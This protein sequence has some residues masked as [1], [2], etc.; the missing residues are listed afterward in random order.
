MTLKRFFRRARWDDERARELESYV[1][2]ETDENIA[3]G[4][5]PRA[6]R[7]AAIRKLGNRTRVREDIYRMNT[8]GFLDS[9]W[10]DVRYGARLLRLNPGFAIV[11]ILS[12][13]LGIGA[14]TA[15]FELLNALRIRS[16]PVAHP[17]Q[18]AEV[19]VVG[20]VS[21]KSGWFSGNHP[22]LTYPLWERIRDRQD[23]F[24]DAFAFSSNDFELSEHGESRTAHG[25]WVSGGF[26]TT[27]AVSPAAGRLLADADDG[28]G[29]QAPPVA[30]GYGFWQREFGGSPAAV[31]RTLTLDGHAHEIAGVMPRSFS[32]IEVGRGLDV[33]V[34]LCAEALSRGP[35]SALSRQDAWFLGVMGR[36]K[37]G[38]SLARATAHLDALSPSLF[39]ETLPNYPADEAKKYLAF[40]L[41]AVPGGT[42][43][44]ELRDAYESPL[45][46]LLGTAGVVLLI[47]CA[48]L[49]NLMLARATA[50]SREI[51]VRLAL[52]ASR[53]RIVRQ[54]VA[55]SVLLAALGAAAAA[56][57]ARVLSRALVASL[58]TAN[59]PIVVDVAFDWR[60]FAF[61]AA[62]AGT[63]CLLFG[64]APAL[65]ATATGPVAALK[66]G[67]R[68]TIG[69]DGFALRRGLVVAQVALSLVLLVAALMFV[70]SFRNLAT[71][72]AGFAK[73]DLLIA[74]FGIRRTTASNEQ[75]AAGY[76][77]LLDRIRHA[78][79]V[80]EAARV[81]NV[82]IG[83]SS[84]DRQVSID[85]VER[86]EA[87]NYNSV[88]DR[89]FSTM[90]APLVAGRD[91]DTRDAAASPR[92]AIVTQSFARVFFGGRNPIGKTFQIVEAPGKPRPPIEIVGLARD[93]K[94]AELR[95]PF[96]S[97][98]YVP[99][100]QDD[101]APG[102][103]RL[104]VR[105]AV[106]PSTLSA[107][108]LALA[109]EAQP[110][111]VVTFRTM[112][113]QIDDSLLRERLVAALSAV[114]GGLAAL[115]AAVGLYG[116]LSYMVV[117][118][119]NEIGV[120]LALGA[121]RRDVLR[122]VMREAGV[123]LAAGL[124]IGLI[125]AVALAR[126]ASAILFQL[127]PTDPATLAVAAAGFALV[128][129]AAS[130]VPA[131][132]AAR[133]EPT[134]ALRQL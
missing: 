97:L 123:L 24:S 83:G 70:R 53:L 28:R 34:P 58:T 85:G 16:L 46:L 55:E 109:R 50:R 105:S 21:A 52:G 22:E 66:A 9:A 113:A 68:G 86:P 5:A 90:G 61:V 106:P 114:F 128:A 115:I 88:S 12:L 18:L 130:V 134:E 37:P 125:G 82:P 25:A 65:R 69:A 102:F 131:V 84:S 47:A 91:F 78:P 71:V 124:V 110:S 81:R 27:L 103:A 122:M 119:R 54:L 11:A 14:N 38:W 44:S 10:R 64:V 32:G 20:D 126:M 6:A 43:V 80:V 72:D 3:R 4:M 89:Y 95:E 19:R 121:D 117:R 8:I 100:A 79:G 62:L 67:G 99:V 17:E 87:V 26:F 111:S 59:Q 31:G 30:I 33:A 41:A 51:A 92:V 76:A 120:R 127:K 39:K 56:L 108:I 96:Q 98:M 73:D 7:L 1:A 63:A 48:N 57:V 2:I 36:L 40:R 45:W 107:T 129:I 13:A 75:L 133:L 42:G 116:V 60:V 15:V 23:A 112:E 132:R 94:Y 77:E 101:L 118:R 104:I 49:A 93:S 74:R 35:R 29:C